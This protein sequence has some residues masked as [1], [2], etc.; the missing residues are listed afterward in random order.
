[1]A[2]PEDS[3]SF[4]RNVTGVASASF[5]AEFVAGAGVWGVPVIP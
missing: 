4:V 3:A 5:T 2:A 1:L